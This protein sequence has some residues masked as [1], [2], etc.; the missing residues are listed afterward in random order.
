MNFIERDDDQSLLN[1]GIFELRQKT[2]QGQKSS[3]YTR[4]VRG[5]KVTAHD[6][7]PKV[8]SVIPGRK[9]HSRPYSHPGDRG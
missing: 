3:T 7:G 2:N 8:K 5:A 6:V 4:V 9:I 1:P